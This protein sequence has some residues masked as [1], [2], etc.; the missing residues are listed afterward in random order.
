MGYDIPGMPVGPRNLPARVEAWQRSAPTQP[1]YAGAV[2][3]W[4]RTE[5][6]EWW[7]YARGCAR[8][9]LQGQVPPIIQVH[10][11]VLQR[12]EAALLT[13][14]V[15]YSRQCGGD[16][17]YQPVPF[18]LA[19]RMPVM[20]GALAVSGWINHRRKVAAEREA[21]VR[22]RLQQTVNVIVTTDRLLC[23]TDQ[24][25]VNCWYEDCT[26]FYPDLQQW[27]LTLGFDEMYPVRFN[28]V[29]VPALALWAGY[30][31]LGDAW[32]NDPRLA[33]LLA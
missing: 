32:A 9:L 2:S 28:G 30:G 15:G 23:G 16:G 24:G 33:S 4:L 31:V 5:H 25:S 10:G 21:A 11:P 22:W 14:D 8:S 18:L 26:G 3:G 12:D 19:G 1:Q 13:A 29:A 20:A 6:Q 7:D 27:T 17:S